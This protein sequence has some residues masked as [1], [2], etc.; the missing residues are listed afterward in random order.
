MKK[1]TKL[2]KQI[3]EAHLN[4]A[5]TGEWSAPNGVATRQDVIDRLKAGDTL[6]GVHSEVEIRSNTSVTSLLIASVF[7][8]HSQAYKREY[9]KTFKILL[10]NLNIQ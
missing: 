9:S 8:N 5:I 4:S 3:I 7:N 2:Q 1:I 10:N 6:Q